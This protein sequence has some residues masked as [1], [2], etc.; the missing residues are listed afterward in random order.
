MPHHLGHYLKRMA[1]SLGALLLQQAIAFNLNTSDESN[2]RAQTS[3][4][5]LSIYPGLEGTDTN[6]A[7]ALLLHDAFENQI[8]KKKR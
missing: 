6:K 2:M 4:G 8:N 1:V 3:S 5:F 7:T